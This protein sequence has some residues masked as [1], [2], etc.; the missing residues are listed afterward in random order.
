M[1][2]LIV[3][4]VNNMNFSV[5]LKEFKKEMKRNWQLYALLLIVAAYFIIFHYIPIY[6]LQI[7]FKD[8]NA[9]KG[10]WGSKWVGF[11][12]FNRFFNSY[13][14]ERLL[15]NTFSISVYQLAV[16]FP[17]PIIFALM[18]NEVKNK[19]YKK[20]VQNMTYIPHFISVVVVVGMV[21]VFLDY[22]NGI[23]NRL[24]EAVGIG[25][26][27][28]M[29]SPEWFKTIFVFSGVW[30]NAGWNSIIYLAALTNVDKELYDA[31]KVDGASRIKRIRHIN[32][33]CIAPTVIILLILNMGNLLTVGY[34][35]ALLMQNQLNISASDVISTYVYRGG[36]LEAQYSFATAVS[37]FN[38]VISFGLVISA[39]YISRKL[40][41][42]YLW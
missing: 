28:F 41:D 23:V 35:K 6:G 30:Q 36:I 24:M 10:I 1:T 11:K 20:L 14:F 33:P 3:R 31:A 26:I 40:S 18:L 38:S 9:A 13:Y 17:I 27:K 7:A 5:K 37:L 4:E 2:R 29:E 22:N 21:F 42:V 34:Q 32:L 25:R 16:G 8:F 12:H 39:N 19:H 15:W